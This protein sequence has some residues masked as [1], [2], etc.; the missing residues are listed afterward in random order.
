LDEVGLDGAAIEA[1]AAADEGKYLN[2]IEEN[3]IIARATGHA[4]VPN[5]VFRGEPF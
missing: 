4:G 2:V 1:R 3:Q 5:A